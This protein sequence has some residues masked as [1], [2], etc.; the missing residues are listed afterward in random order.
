M[1]TPD[2]AEVLFHADAI[3]TT[4]DAGEVNQADR[5]AVLVALGT[6][7]AGD[8]H[9]EIRVGMGKARAFRHGASH[10]FAHDLAALNDLRIETQAVHL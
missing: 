4:P 10:L 7:H 1:R 9:R 6:S 2:V 3:S 8:R 5:I